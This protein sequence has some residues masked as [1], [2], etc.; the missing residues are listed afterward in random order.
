LKEKVGAAD[1]NVSVT[2]NNSYLES[3]LSLNWQVLK[4]NCS[5]QAE[6][7]RK[8]LE[9]AHKDREDIIKRMGGKAEELDLARDTIRNLESRAQELEKAVVQERTRAEKTL[10]VSALGDTCQKCQVV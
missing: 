8:E 1:K 9:V 3:L 7:L 6:E 5:G 10:K 4:S 2:I